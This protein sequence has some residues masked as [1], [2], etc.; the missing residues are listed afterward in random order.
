[1]DNLITINASLTYPL[2]ELEKFADNRG[3][4]S[5]IANPDY[6]ATFDLETGKQ[7]DNGLPQTLPNPETRTEFVKR[8]FKDQAVTLFAVDFKRDAEAQA[9]DMAKQLEEVAKAQLAQAINIE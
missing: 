5:V 7:T 1:M 8:W 2:S 3:Y 6:V 4:Q 9:R